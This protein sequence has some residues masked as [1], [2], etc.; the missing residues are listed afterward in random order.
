MKEN[1]K[2]FG[3]SIALAVVAHGCYRPRLFSKSLNKYPRHAS[4]WFKKSKKQAS[5]EK[6]EDKFK[7]QIKNFEEGFEVG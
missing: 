3:L 6:E 2:S 4:F 5:R 7:Y 1:L